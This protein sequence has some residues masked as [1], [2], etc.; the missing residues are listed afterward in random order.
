M[1]QHQSCLSVAALA[2]TSID[3]FSLSLQPS[4]F[5]A[6]LRPQIPVPAPSVVHEHLN[7]GHFLPTASPSCVTSSFLLT[8]YVP[9][10]QGSSPSCAN[11]SHRTFRGIYPYVSRYCFLRTL[12][13]GVVPKQSFPVE[14]MFRTL[15]FRVSVTCAIVL[16]V[17][18]DFPRSC[19]G[20]KN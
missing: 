14:T 5:L 16:H 8:E 1:R 11:R 18:V 12:D 15:I 19:K 4:S 20:R 10:G 3:A 17:S 13:G 6:L 2:A 7:S 9:E